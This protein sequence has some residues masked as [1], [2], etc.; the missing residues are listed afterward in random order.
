MHPRVELLVKVEVEKLLDVSF[1]R[2]IDYLEWI[3]NLLHVRKPD[4]NIRIC[5]DFRDINMACP[6]DEFSL[7]NIDLII[8]LI[9]GHAMLSFIDGFSGY[10][11]IKIAPEDQH[12]TIFTCLWGT[13]C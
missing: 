1:I 8:Y 12:K 9:V 5:T 13:F 4:G 2:P 11:Q 3:S 7:P 10:N 6:K